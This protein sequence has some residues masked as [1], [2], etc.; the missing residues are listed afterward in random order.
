[1]RI[2]LLDIE[3]G[4]HTAGLKDRIDS[5]VA[6]V[7][8][9]VKVV[10]NVITTL[11][12]AALD[13]GIVLALEWLVDEFT[14]NTGLYCKLRIDTENI[15][16]SEK[17]AI[18]IFRTAQES[19]NNAARHATAGMVE[20]SFRQTETD[21]I[22]TVTDDGKGFDPAEKKEKS[23]GL[24]GIQERIL[25]LGG[26]VDIMSAPHTGTSIQVSI[27]TSTA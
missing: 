14:V 26:E 25:M 12:P 24:V 4:S 19:L 5:M 15:G 3:F 16:L 27:P 18:A 20:V 13:L 6:L 8:T 22:L 2:S 1:M 23:F 7:D 9:A 17:G 11:R 21:Y 10:R